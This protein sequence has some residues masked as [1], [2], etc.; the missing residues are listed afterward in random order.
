MRRFPAWVAALSL[1]CGLAGC[2][3]AGAP[4]AFKAQ[5]N[6]RADLVSDG[7]SKD[8]VAFEVMVKDESR[9]E[10][11]VEEIK[12]I[13]KIEEQEDAAEEGSESAATEEESRPASE[14]DRK[15]SVLMTVDP[16]SFATPEQIKSMINDKLKA[17]FPKRY[18][19]YSFTLPK[20][21]SISCPSAKMDIKASVTR[22]LPG[23]IPD[24]KGKVDF[25]SPVIARVDTGT[26][27][28]VTEATLCMGKLQIKKID[29][30]YVPSFLE[31]GLRS[32]VNNVLN[33]ALPGKV[34]AD[35]QTVKNLVKAQLAKGGKLQAAPPTR[36]QA[37][38]AAG[39]E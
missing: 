22:S 35:V 27:T 11:T 1:S 21:V 15:T 5:V 39:S 8:K 31:S 16:C 7:Q 33:K 9:S 28:Q 18:K 36:A 13:E 2:G 30:K 26:G 32:V 38:T 10:P 37:A 6:A 3:Q 20:S 29:F 25:A 4:P 14:S 17:M 23:P 34:C 12:K 24:L 19:K